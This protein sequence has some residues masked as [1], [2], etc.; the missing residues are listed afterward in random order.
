[1]GAQHGQPLAG[2]VLRRSLQARAPRPYKLD[3]P[4]SRAPYKPDAPLS[5]AP[6]KPDAPLSR[7]PYKPDAP[8]SRAPHKPGARARAVREPR[9][10]CVRAP[11]GE[12]TDSLGEGDGV[13]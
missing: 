4:L 5:R 1:M 3:A 8:L 9:R 7:A 2:F 12:L 11:C 13:D 6:H 10:E